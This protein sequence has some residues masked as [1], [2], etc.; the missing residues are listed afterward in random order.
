MKKLIG[1]DFG[2]PRRAGD[3][4]KKIILIEAIKCSNARYK[5]LPHGRNTRLVRS[6]GSDWRSR[7]RGWTIDELRDSLC[8][9][10]TVA[11]AAFDFPFSLPNQLLNDPQFSGLVGHNTAFATR[12]NWQSLVAQKL[13]LQ[14]DSDKATGQLVGLEFFDVWRGT[15][16]WIP[17][18]TDKATNA[19]PP[20]KDKFQSV[21]NMTI[22]GASLLHALVQEGYQEK[23]EDVQQGKAVMETYPRVVAARM[24]FEDS[25]KRKPLACL[26]ASVEELARREIELEFDSDVHQFCKTYTSGDR[27]HDGVDAF[28][29]LITSICFDHGAAELCG[30]GDA[31]EGA[32]IAPIVS[33]T[34]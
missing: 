3:Q 29:C 28:L 24:G 10:D 26:E 25:Y 22:A 6:L 20:L 34:K 5:I 27:D 21:F 8:S 15:K 2:V 23:L 31:E 32:I 4:A 9:D 14:F 30:Q 18:V 1:V 11:A 12:T 33:E 17:R 16:F 13:S 7:R 19:S